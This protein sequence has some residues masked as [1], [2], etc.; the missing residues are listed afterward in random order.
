MTLAQDLSSQFK[1]RILPA[2]PA[3][4]RGLLSHGSA[5]HLVAK[6][7]QRLLLFNNSLINLE[8]GQ[9]TLID[10]ADN[11]LPVAELARAAKSLIRVEEPAGVMLYLQPSDF[12]ATSVNMPGLDRELLLSALNLQADNLFPSFSEKLNVTLGAD[13]KNAGDSSIALWFPERIMTELFNE[14]AAQKLFL[15]AIAPRVVIDTTCPTLIDLDRNGGTVVQFEDG[16]LTNWMH[17]NQLDLEDSA[18]NQEWTSALD[19]LHSNALT[20]D[21]PDS[22]SKFKNATQSEDFAFVPSGALKARKREEKGRNITLAAAAVVVLMVFASIPFLLQSIQF[23]SL[24]GSLAEIRAESASAREDQSVVVN[25]ENEWG[26]ITDFPVQDVQGAMFTLQNIL[27]PDQL[28]SLELTEGLIKIQG[29]SAEPQAILQR[30]EQDPMFTEV[31]F[32][33]A[34]N[35][36]RYY[37][38]LRLSAVNFEGYMVRYFPDE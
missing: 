7:D 28:A 23:R 27:L 20:M 32:S 26:V 21:C 4:I 19:K 2:M 31:V 11:E 5:K 36:S 13:A 14:F 15:V 3:P 1:A 8:S 38:D 24:A 35:N 25:F 12:V 33:R 9:S 10:A 34:T 37:I 16:V 29:T 6:V 22:F 17:I 30:L 18:L